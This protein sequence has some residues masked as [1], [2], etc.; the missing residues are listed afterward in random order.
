M[1]EIVKLLGWTYVST[2]AAEVLLLFSAK[3]LYDLIY[4]SVCQLKSEWDKRDNLRT[5]DVV[6][7][8]SLLLLRF[9]QSL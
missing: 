1:I 6:I 7:L 4:P 2:V 8:V 5:M 9:K 3:L